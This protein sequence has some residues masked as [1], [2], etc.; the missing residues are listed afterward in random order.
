MLQIVENPHHM[1]M[2]DRRE[3]PS[4]RDEP[5]ADLLVVRELRRDL[6][7]RDRPAQPAMRARE[8]HPAPAPAELGADVVGG[9]GSPHQFVL[10]GHD[11]DPSAGSR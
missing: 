10:F 1:R 2:V 6:L 9:Q 7:D 5:A 11:A 3:H 4:L 8:H